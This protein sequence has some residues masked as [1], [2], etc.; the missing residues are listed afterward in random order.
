M[1]RAQKDEAFGDKMRGAD[2]LLP[3]IYD[4]AELFRT[5]A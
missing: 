1:E 2:A 5:F 3:V 4:I